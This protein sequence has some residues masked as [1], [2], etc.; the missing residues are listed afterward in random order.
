MAQLLDQVATRVTHQ[1]YWHLNQYHRSSTLAAYQALG[2]EIVQQLARHGAPAPQFFA[3][4]V[5]TGG[6][7][8][9]VGTYVRQIFPALK[10]VAVEPE[11]QVTIPGMRNTHMLHLGQDD[12]YDLAFPD[13]RLTTLPAGNLVRVAG[14][15]LGGSATAV[16]HALQK[17][18]WED[19]LLIAAD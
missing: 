10:V 9:G 19:V 12:P 2:H 17:T 5:G 15:T 4:P 16:Y 18:A 3:C 6:L 1:G 14:I 13:L 11:P 7:I 8:Q